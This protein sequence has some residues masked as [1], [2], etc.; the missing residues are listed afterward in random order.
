MKFAYVTAPLTSA[1]CE[2]ALDQYETAKMFACTKETLASLHHGI[3]SSNKLTEELDRQIKN[4]I[5]R[6]TNTIRIEGCWTW[7]QFKLI[8][9]KLYI[10]R[11]SNWSDE[12]KDSFILSAIALINLFGSAFFSMQTMEEAITQGEINPAV[13]SPK[14]RIQELTE[15]AF[16]TES[17][18]EE[19]AEIIDALSEMYTA[20]L[21]NSPKEVALLQF[22][23]ERRLERIAFIVPKAYYAELFPRVFQDE[24]TNVTCITANRFNKQ[25][26]YDRIISTADIIGKRFDA[27]QCYSAPEINLF[28][29]GFEEKTFSF[30]KQKNAKSERKLNARIKGFIG[31]EYYKEIGKDDTE[32]YGV[33]K[34]TM[35][36]FS[37]LDEYVDSISVFDIRKLAASVSGG[38]SNNAAEVKFVGVFTTGEQILFSKYYSAVVFD[39]DSGSVTETKPDKLMPGDVLVFTRKND[40]T[41]NIVDQVFEQLMQTKK[42]SEEVEV[43]AEKAI[44]WK[45]KLREYKATNNLTYKA[46]ARELKKHGSS[47]Q[48]VSIR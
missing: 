39:Q 17:L 18:K 1:S 27:L 42:L 46:L 41:S 40:Y 19:C 31:D 9:E 14:K 15:I 38:E 6:Q 43:A 21:N 25:Q 8:K 10:I 47:L 3:K 28:L 32:D 48:E 34:D 24:F 23:R 5:I 16:K 22:L 11:Q 30:R 44:H 4:I 2:F 20:L 45:T 13:V 7:E 33:L 35:Q 29:Y 36:E 26:E 12:N 37:D